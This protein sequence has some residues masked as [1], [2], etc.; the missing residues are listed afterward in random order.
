VY[1]VDY[2]SVRS[3]SIFKVLV[4]NLSADFFQRLCLQI[5]REIKAEPLSLWR[6]LCRTVA[7]IKLAMRHSGYGFKP[8]QTADTRLWTNNSP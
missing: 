3:F 4:T 6:S 7:E 2:F 5:L 8:Y 1:I